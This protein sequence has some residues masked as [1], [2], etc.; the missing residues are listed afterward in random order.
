MAS[1]EVSSKEIKQELTRKYAAIILKPVLLGVGVMLFWRYVL[2]EN[3][4]YFNQD[5]ET[6]ILYLIIPLVGF[7]YVIFAS[8]A[9]NTA[10]DK[11]KAITKSVT[12]AD[13]EAYLLHRESKTP[14]LIHILIGAPSL[15]LVLLAVLFNYPDLHIGAVAVFAVVFVVSQTWIIVMELDN[16]HTRK[17]FK[18][19][20]PEHWHATD[21]KMFFREK[22][23]KGK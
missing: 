13:I 9:V 15:I 17:S 18:A 20:V 16:F 6:P 5:A 3:G 12:Q 7:I 11:Y 21:A 10:L 2:Y 4:I 8:I 1:K 22:Q 14:V 23:S 19:Q